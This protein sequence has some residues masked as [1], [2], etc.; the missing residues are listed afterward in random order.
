MTTLNSNP[1][2][3]TSELCTDPPARQNLDGEF[4][5]YVYAVPA[6]CISPETEKEFAA[7]IPEWRQR[8]FDLAK[9]GYKQLQNSTIRR[10]GPDKVGAEVEYFVI[11][12]NGIPNTNP[13]VTAALTGLRSVK[14]WL[15][16]HISSRCFNT[17]TELSK[18]NVEVNHPAISAQGHSLFSTFASTATASLRALNQEAGALGRLI[19]PG[20][21]PYIPAVATVNNRYAKAYRNDGYWA[22]P[23]CKGIYKTNCRVFL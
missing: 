10:F 20:T 22:H 2:N 8:L 7:S 12:S 23:R 5:S 6:D 9:E 14:D 3:L 21:S 19:L 11:D 18:S 15:G 4:R 1:E 16:Q 17:T 13:T